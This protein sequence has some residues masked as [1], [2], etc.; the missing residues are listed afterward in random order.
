MYE[1]GAVV[2]QLAPLSLDDTATVIDTNKSNI[3]DAFGQDEPMVVG[4]VEAVVVEWVGAAHKHGSFHQLD[5]D[6][7]FEMDAARQVTTYPETQG[8]ATL[9]SDPVDG[10]LDATSIHCHAV[11]ADAELG[12]VVGGFRVLRCGLESHEQGEAEG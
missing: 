3:F 8:A 9:F 6:I 11:A 1:V 4:G 5:G 2:A 10:E 12:G 7:G